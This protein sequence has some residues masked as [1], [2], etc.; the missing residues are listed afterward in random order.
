MPDEKWNVVFTW[1]DSDGKWHTESEII[2]AATIGE[3]IRDADEYLADTMESEDWSDYW[4][5]GANIV[6][7]MH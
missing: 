1:H 2:E 5:I 4:I 3:A 7:E 6:P